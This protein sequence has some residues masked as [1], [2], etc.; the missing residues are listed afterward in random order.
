MEDVSA[1]SSA[2]SAILR[3]SIREMQQ[4][5]L[6]EEMG[7][8]RQYLKIIDIRYQNRFSYEIEI[9]DDVL[10]CACPCMIIQPLVENAI[11]HGVAASDG[12]G[13][14]RI[15]GRVEGG[16]VRIEVAD[17]GAGI[18]AEKLAELQQ[19]LQLQLFDMMEAHEKY[20]KSFGLL[21]IQRRIQLQYGEEYGL[22][23]LSADG[24]TRLLLRFP[25]VKF[26]KPPIGE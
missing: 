17:N 21:N 23:L 16:V 15:L 8:V 7:I 13:T 1:I 18:S 11:I 22:T 2:L 4:V 9:G 10:D 14:I 25:A 6:R 3:Y 26:V 20:G 24:W 12:G 19:R 5:S